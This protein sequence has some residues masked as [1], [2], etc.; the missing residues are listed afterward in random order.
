MKANEGTIDRIIRAVVGIAALLGAFA[1]GPGTVGVR[2]CC[3]W[4]A[5]SCW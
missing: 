3:W 4:S 1:L 2:R 5:P